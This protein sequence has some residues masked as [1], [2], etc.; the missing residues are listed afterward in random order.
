MGTRVLRTRLPISLGLSGLV[1]LSVARPK[2]ERARGRLRLSV[3]EEANEKRFTMENNRPPG[4]RS[5]P[6]PDVSKGLV[7]RSRKD[8]LTRK[9]TVPKGKGA[10]SIPKVR[11]GL[12]SRR[13]R[14]RREGRRAFE[15]GLS[16]PS[17][18][19]CRS[20]TKCFESDQLSF[21]LRCCEHLPR[22]VLNGCEPLKQGFY[23]SVHGADRGR[24]SNRPR[25][26]R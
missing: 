25:P 19:L 8:Q 2:R 1:P 9:R 14:P 10:E 12:A 22:T 7:S 13:P 11:S 3:G 5:T 24:Y 4:R 20:T 16:S 17:C 6:L 18:N 15:N 23:A 21:S 26:P